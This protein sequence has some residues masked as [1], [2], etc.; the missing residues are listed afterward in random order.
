MNAKI[1][2][3]GNPHNDW[4]SADLLEYTDAS[5]FRTGFDAQKAKTAKQKVADSRKALEYC[6]F[7]HKTHNW[8]RDGFNENSMT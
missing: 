5:A 4:K 8:L 1:N 7:G 6:F 3:E 2:L